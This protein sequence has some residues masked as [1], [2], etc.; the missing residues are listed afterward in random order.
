MGF[1]AVPGIHP[2][3]VEPD[4]PILEL[5][6]VRGDEAQR[7]VAELELAVAGRHADVAR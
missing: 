4:E 5:H 1:P 6:V 3:T 2:V 7:R